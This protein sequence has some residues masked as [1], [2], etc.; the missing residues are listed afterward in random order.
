MSDKLLLGM[1]GIERV[2]ITKHKWACD[3]YWSFGCVGNSH[4]HYHFDKKYLDGSWYPIHL[5]FTETKITEH[6]WWN[7]LDL[8]KQAYGLKKAA[9]V[10]KHGGNLAY[11]N[12]VV[13]IIDNEEKAD[14]VNRDLEIVLNH[15]WAYLESILG[16]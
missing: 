7:I 13:T 6:Q 16:E 12:E 5:L 2:F 1:N 10:Y 11:A 3:W 4:G 8:F 14:V 9:A 15:L